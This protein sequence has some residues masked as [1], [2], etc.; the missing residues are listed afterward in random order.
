MTYTLNKANTIMPG[1]MQRKMKGIVMILGLL[2]LANL[3]TAMQGNAEKLNYPELANSFSKKNKAFWTGDDE[4][5]LDLRTGLVGLIDKASSKGLTKKRFHPA[6]LHAYMDDVASVD[7]KTAELYFADAAI[8]YC[9]DLVKAPEIS[10]LLSYDDVSPKN[11]FREDEK[12]LRSLLD[13]RS[14]KDLEEVVASLEPDD[15]AYKTLASALKEQLS[16]DKKDLLVIKKIKYSLAYYRWIKHFNFEKYIVVNIASAR[17]RYYEFNDVALSMKVVAGDAPTET[18]RFAAYCNQLT[19]YPYW[20]VPRSI[21]TKEILPFCQENEK[22]I[23]ALDVDVL[24]RNGKV[25][26]PTKLNWK[27]FTANNFPYNF[28]HEPGCDNPLGLIRFNLT[29]PFDIYLHDTNL[30]PVFKQKHRHYSH[31]CIRL[32]KPD[33]L[34]NLFLDE[35][36]DENFLTDCLEDQKPRSKSF[37]PVPVFVVYMPAEATEKGVTVYNDFYKLL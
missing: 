12:L 21:A 1:I 11:N 28:R 26:D 10:K 27:K 31:G 3:G 18:P 32:E 15:Q 7:R 36:L 24:D 16:L 29:D 8:T 20:H 14:V 34:A 2:L 23:A 9:K 19:L 37:K 30:K 4:R 22:D 35:K 5:S 25:V 17:L 33:Q 6:L 13:M